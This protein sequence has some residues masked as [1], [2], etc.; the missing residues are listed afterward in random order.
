[1]VPRRSRSGEV[2]LVQGDAA[3]TREI[4]RRAARQGDPEQSRKLVALAKQTMPKVAPRD[5]LRELARLEATYNGGGVRRAK[6]RKATSPTGTAGKERRRIPAKLQSRTS[7]RVVP[8][9]AGPTPVT[10]DY[11]YRV[12]D[13]GWH[14]RDPLNPQQ[15]VCGTLWGAVTRVSRVLP[16]GESP[17]SVCKT[18]PK[19]RRKDSS[20][21]PS[22]AAAQRSRKKPSKTLRSKMDQL[23][24]QGLK[25]EYV[26]ATA[27]DQLAREASRSRSLRALSGG[28]PT[29]G[30][31][32]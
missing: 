1:M 7:P 8:A 14:R 6:K 12:D 15:T 24:S 10:I 28:L 11:W 13:D 17:C 16:S 32:K 9:G 19:P 30:R 26:E 18:T 31:R 27:L 29:L 5:L 22:A 20:G 21:R 25:E 2:S 3:L 23:R 4:L